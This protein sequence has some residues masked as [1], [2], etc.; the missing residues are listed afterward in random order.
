[1]HG[2]WYC[3]LTSNFLILIRSFRPIFSPLQTLFSLTFISDSC[4]YP[5]YAYL[6][7]HLSFY[8]FHMSRPI[9]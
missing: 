2:C 7:I 8:T 3:I 6:F 9:T 1:M 4:S 5:S